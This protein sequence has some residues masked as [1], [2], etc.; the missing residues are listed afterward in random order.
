MTELRV[1][2]PEEVDRHLEA[3]VRTGMFSNKAELV[4]SALLSYVN[5]VQPISRGYDRQVIYSP[6]GRVYQVEYAREAAKKGLPAVGLVGKGAVVLAAASPTVQ[7]YEGL[8]AEI[9]K[10][11]QLSGELAIAG[12]G[13]VWDFMELADALAE[14][15]PMDGHQAIRVLRTTYAGRTAMA[16]VRPY[17]AMVLL[18]TCFEGMPHLYEFD[19]SGTFMGLRAAAIGSG[20]ATLRDE[21]RELPKDLKVDAL[22]E[23]AARV[24]GDHPRLQ[25][26]RLTGGH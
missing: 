20:G 16:D 15:G 7:G 26:A 3:S 18:A 4:R 14:E 5:T 17:G 21:L 19:V 11:V 24:L 12:S 13:M 10:V 25:V 6:E 9:P 23:A 2:L 1:V 22:E 8:D